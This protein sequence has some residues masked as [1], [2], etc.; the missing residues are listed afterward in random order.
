MRN[1]LLE[2]FVGLLDCARAARDGVEFEARLAAKGFISETA[3]RYCGEI[4]KIIGE[5]EGNP[6][7]AADIWSFLC[8]VHVLSL[9][10]HTST[11]QTEAHI[12]SLL[13]HTVTEGDPLCAADASWNELLAFASKA[14]DE[15][16]S[17]RRGAMPEELQRRHKSVGANEQ[18]ILRALKEHTDLI[19]RGIRPNLG[20]SFHLARAAL[21]QKVLTQL[22]TSQIVLLSGPAGSGKS[23]I[24]REVVTLLSSDHFIFGFRGEEFAQA[25]LDATLHAGQIPTNASTL[26]AILAAQ[27][28]KIVIVESVER[29]LEKPTR[30][31]FTDLMTL[32]SDDAS[33]RIVLTC[34]DYSI[35][36]VRASFLQSA[37]IKHAVVTVPPLEDAELTAA[38]SAFP[39]LAYPLKNPALRRILR[40]VSLRSSRQSDFG[41][42][43]VG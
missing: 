39:M 22:Q 33:M 27:D 37:G 19:L 12:K 38:E 11:R 26:G 21:T 35:D 10:F 31:A 4:Q 23:V 8:V 17:L 28:R 43:Q 18:R 29:L 36:Q 7:N 42:V 1:T 16:R 34:R 32:A 3:V 40:K 5:I 20:Q 2:H 25:H 15:A 14:M 13:T 30:D 41:S 24:G 9:D 6:V